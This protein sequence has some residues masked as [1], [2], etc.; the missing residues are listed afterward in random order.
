VVVGLASSGAVIVD[1]EGADRLVYDARSQEGDWERRRPGQQF[2]AGT[3]V[4][5][6]IAWELGT[7]GVDADLRAAVVSGIETA[8]VLHE[9]GFQA[10]ATESGIRIAFPYDRVA[11]SIA[12]GVDD[13]SDIECVE[14]SLDPTWRVFDSA[15]SF[16]ESAEQIARF[17]AVLH[18]SG[19]DAALL[20]T[21][22]RRL[23]A[24]GG[25]R[26]SLQVA[27][28]E[29]AFIYLMAGARDNFAGN[30]KVAA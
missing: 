18:V 28:L 4:V 11:E 17:G 27:G 10:T 20:E 8:R 15:G 21:T 25:Y 3:M 7:R 19:T 12:G 29:E 26:W 5:D 24:E 6:A 30:P 9:Q 23:E 1:R 13:D 22:V 16:R 14:V 2:G